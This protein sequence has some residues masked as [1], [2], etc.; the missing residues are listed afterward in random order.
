M[1]IDG[2]L[3]VLRRNHY[4][5]DPHRHVPL[6]HDRNLRLRIRSKP[7]NL[8][9]LTQLC[10]ILNQTVCELD[11]QRHQRLG[12]I[13][14]ETEHQALIAGTLLRMQSLSR[15]D[16][17]TYVGRLLVNGADHG[18][19]SII[20]SARRVVIPDPANRF[21]NRFLGAAQRVLCVLIV[22]GHFARDDGQ[23]RGHHRLDR[24]AR[25]WV[26][27]DEAIEQGV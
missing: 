22:N 24:Y 11:R 10:E 21:A 3:R 12:F 15:G 23:P 5:V 14:G 18:A 6:V 17:L 8:P 13:A 27:A 2:F 25:L 7:G 20:E 19:T 4:G 9:G 16:T 26:E 1:G